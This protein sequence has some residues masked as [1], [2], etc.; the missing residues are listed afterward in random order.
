MLIGLL[1]LVGLKDQNLGLAIISGG[2]LVL[3]GHYVH[4]I[5]GRVLETVR[6]IRVTRD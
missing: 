4:E 1:L 2:Y 5:S 3:D 6:R